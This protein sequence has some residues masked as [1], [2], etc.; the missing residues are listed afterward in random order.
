MEK[1]RFIHHDDGEGERTRPRCRRY[2]WRR[3][4]VRRRWGGGIWSWGGD[5]VDAAGNPSAAELGHSDLEILQAEVNHHHRVTVDTMRTSNNEERCRASWRRVGRGR[6]SCYVLRDGAATL[7]PGMFDVT[8]RV[9]PV[10]VDEPIVLPP[11]L[12]CSILW[13]HYCRWSR[14]F[15]FMLRDNYWGVMG[16]RAIHRTYA[17]VVRD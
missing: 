13:L 11:L 2:S 12:H 15:I 10:K 6:R 5:K 9:G 14:Q 17:R 4:G 1:T 16:F 8:L 7:V 3:R